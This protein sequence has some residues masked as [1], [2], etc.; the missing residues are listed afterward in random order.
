MAWLCVCGHNRSQH[1][2]APDFR[3]GWDT[4]CDADAVTPYRR[5]GGKPCGCGEFRERED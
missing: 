4:S 2:L 3:G 5:I 1:R